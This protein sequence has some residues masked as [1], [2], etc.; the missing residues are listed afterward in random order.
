MTILELEVRA[1]RA[2]AIA[3][4]T[5]LGFVI[6]GRRRRYYREPVDDALLMRLD[7]AKYK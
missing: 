4:Y 5:G 6:V 1:G 2:G 7:L 3:L